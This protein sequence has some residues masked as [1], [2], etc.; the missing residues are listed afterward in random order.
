MLYDFS[1]PVTHDL[2][3][4]PER[5][6]L[7][8]V[9]SCAELISSVPFSVAKQ[10]AGLEIEDTELVGSDT[11]SN[12]L[13]VAH[14]DSGTYTKNGQEYSGNYAILMRKF[15]YPTPQTWD[16]YSSFSASTA[17]Y[18]WVTQTYPEALCSEDTKKSLISVPTPVNTGTYT[19]ANGVSTYSIPCMLPSSFNVGGTCYYATQTGTWDYFLTDAT[20]KRKA[21]LSNNTTSY[22]PWPTRQTGTVSEGSSQYYY[23]V[24]VSAA[25][26]MIDSSSGGDSPEYLRPCLYIAM[27][28]SS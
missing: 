3:L 9:S 8:T 25:G 16:R 11:V 10:F 14:I 6:Q 28:S 24:R 4:R 17:L 20:N 26:A 18:T 5:I 12:P 15:L 23:R 13:I 27:P 21:A 2:I 22:Q 1:Q 7:Q 19:S